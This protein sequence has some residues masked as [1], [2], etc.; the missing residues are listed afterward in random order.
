MQKN[1]FKIFKII[2]F[3]ICVFVFPLG[4][5]AA[6][7]LVSPASGK[8][9]VGNRVTIKVLINSSGVPFN[10]VSGNLYFPSSIFYVDSV[11]KTNSVLN[12][13]VTEPVVNAGSVKFEGVALGGSGSTSGTIIT[14]NLHAIK[15]G[16]GAAFFISGQVLGNDGQGTDITGSLTGGNFSVE[17]VIINPEPN[18]K[19]KMPEKNNVI[20]APE[21]VP[22]PAPTLTAPE[23]VLGSKYGAQ[24]I[25]GSSNY[26][27]AQTIVTF[28]GENGTKV[29]ILGTAD[30]D[31]SFDLLVPGSLKHG[32]YTVT[33]TMVKSDKTNSQTS[34]SIYI[35]IGGPFS[36]ISN[37][38]M[39]LIFVL[40]LVILY[41]LFRTYIHF[42]KT[43]K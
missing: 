1:Y 18:V 43:Y 32:N 33:A 20:V 25:I 34:S 12:F 30:A 31:G 4:A 24:A 14:V 41:F 7:L 26:P 29:F 11:S 13:W 3:F 2:L 42:N 35:T 37:E 8:F 22:Q 5:Y 6:N 21:E 9:E 27:K 23:I 28:V 15:S 38:T 19:E 40:I 39:G 16:A 36:D 17:E 10:A